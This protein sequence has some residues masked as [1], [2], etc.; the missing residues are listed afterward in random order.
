MSQTVAADAQF[1]IARILRP[2]AGFDNLTPGGGSYQGMTGVTPIMLTE[3][4]KALDDLAGQPGYSPVL[5]RGLSVPMGARVVLYIPNLTPNPPPPNGYRYA[6]LWR[7]RNTHDYALTRT[8]YH[9]PKQGQGIP[10][11]APNPN[12]GARV[13]IPAASD[14]VVYNQ[15]EPVAFASPAVQNVYA[16]ALRFN[17]SLSSPFSPL[18]PGGAFGTIEQGTITSEPST[19]NFLVAET[20]AKGD[21]MVLAI[22]KEPNTTWN[23]TNGASDF[24][25]A[26]ELGQGG[27]QLAPP[28]GPFP[29]LGVYVMV[30][31]SP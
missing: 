11:V 31:T 19:G 27:N 14:T 20:Q 8:P 22:W 13:V 18:V 30:G 4:G 1:G 3:G 16:E 17:F 15:A 7:L 12:P 29:D 5:V 28:I 25:L 10:I 26:L 24:Q 23:F 21:E 9:Y 2:Y 6:V